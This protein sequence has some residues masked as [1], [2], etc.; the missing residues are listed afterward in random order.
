MCR[1]SRA[2]GQPCGRVAQPVAP[3]TRGCATWGQQQ[4]EL[5][6]GQSQV[7]LLTGWRAKVTPRLC[8]L[9]CLRSSPITHLRRDHVRNAWLGNQFLTRFRRRNYLGGQRASP[10][11]E[12]AKSRA[13]PGTISL[14]APPCA[15]EGAHLARPVLGFRSTEPGGLLDKEDLNLSASGAA[16]WP[17]AHLPGPRTLTS[18]QSASASPWGGVGAMADTRRSAASRCCWVHCRWSVWS[19][20]SGR[21]T[22]S[23]N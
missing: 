15:Q 19:S 5:P 2:G 3:C 16:R 12:L 10:R 11:T 17:A 4:P 14:D 23:S 7:P 8:L 13:S 21:T 9:T 22:G 6:K 20:R 1:W 18:M